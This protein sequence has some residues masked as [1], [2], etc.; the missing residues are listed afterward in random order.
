L[1]DGG[2]QFTFLN[3]VM[4]LLGAY[5]QAISRPSRITISRRNLCNVVR[6]SQLCTVLLGTLIHS[7]SQQ[8]VASREVQVEKC[9]VLGAIRS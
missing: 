1:N 7:D 9:G 8:Y 2:V 5:K 6:Y 4:K 3:M